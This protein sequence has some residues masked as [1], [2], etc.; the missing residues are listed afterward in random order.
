MKIY[1]KLPTTNC[2]PNKEEKVA[3]DWPFSKKTHWIHREVGIGP[4]GGKKALSS[5]NTRRLRMEPWQRGRHGARLKDWLL[6]EPGGGVFTDALCSRGRNRNVEDELCATGV[7]NITTAK[8]RL[9]RYFC[10]F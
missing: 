7:Y 6:T 3:M 8:I 5:K 2:N 10:I 9:Y 1:G 4:S